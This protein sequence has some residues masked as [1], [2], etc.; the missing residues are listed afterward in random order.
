MRHDEEYPFLNE[1]SFER[2]LRRHRRRCVQL[3][4]DLGYNAFQYDALVYLEAVEIESLLQCASLTPRQQFVIECYLSG[5]TLQEIGKQLGV[6]KQAISKTL[7][8]ALRKLR[9]VWHVNPL[10]GLAEVYCHEIRR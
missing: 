3:Q 1:D 5:Y 6:S 4:E 10:L 2:K 8:F 9:Q 7:Q